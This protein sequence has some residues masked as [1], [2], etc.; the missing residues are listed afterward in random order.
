MAQHIGQ[1]QGIDARR[2]QAHPIS[3]APHVADQR[4][5]PGFAQRLAAREHHGVQQAGARG[6]EGSRFAPVVPGG[7]GLQFGVV[8]VMAAPG[9]ARDE[10]DGGQ[11]PGPV[12]RG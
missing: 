5:Q 7:A 11:L 10:D 4:R 8:A 9:A 1:A 3:H 6:Q 2:V 12:H